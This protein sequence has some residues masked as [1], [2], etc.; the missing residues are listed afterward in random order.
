MAKQRLPGLMLHV[1]VHLVTM[2]ILIIQEFWVIWPYLVI[3]TVLHFFVD[4]LKVLYGR[5]R[6]ALILGPY[7][8]DQGAHITVLII[9]A[10]VLAQKTDL[11]VWYAFSSWWPMIIG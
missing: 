4:Y 1:A 8:I 7:I 5:R 11:V 6:P 3:I 10:S 9:V 2:V